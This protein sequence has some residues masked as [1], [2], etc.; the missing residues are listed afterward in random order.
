M[1]VPWSTNTLGGCSGA[2]PDVDDS[3]SWAEHE[4]LSVAMALAEK[5]HHSANRTD[6]PS[7]S[8]ARH[9]VLLYG[10]RERAGASWGASAAGSGS[11]AHPGA[12]CRP[13]PVGA[14][15]DAPVPQM[16]DKVMDTFRLMDLPIAEQVIE[17][18]KVSSSSCPSRAVLREPQVVEQWVEVQTVMQTAGHSIVALFKQHTAEQ[19]VDNPVPRGR[20]GRSLQG[21]LPRKNPTAQSVEQIVDTSS[22]GSL[23]DLRPGQGSTDSSSHSPGT[24]DEVFAWFFR[25]FLR[26]K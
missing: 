24:A 25:T 26:V 21:F 4:R 20:G 8:R 13:C 6:L 17:V 7:S 10:P 1:V 19:F 12:S 5:V 18:L 2:K 22:G 3:A 23:Q 16:V 11:A 15:F 9:A 14:N